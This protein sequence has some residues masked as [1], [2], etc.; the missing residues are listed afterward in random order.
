MVVRQKNNEAPQNFDGASRRRH[1]K[2]SQGIFLAL[3]LVSHRH[4]QETDAL[5]LRISAFT[6]ASFIGLQGRFLA[7]LEMTIQ[8]SDV[9]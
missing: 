7:P 6:H 1:R 5:V 3:R 4:W 9:F 2:R 8:E